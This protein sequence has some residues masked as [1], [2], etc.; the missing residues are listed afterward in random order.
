MFGDLDTLL[1]LAR[2][3]E[4]R[5]FFKDARVQALLA[6]PGFKKAVQEKNMFQLASHPKF[7]Q[8][9]QDPDFRSTLEGVIKKIP[10]NK[11]GSL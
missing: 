8:L 2:D 11:P 10:K 6:D 3:E 9:M 4:F 7:N 5:K 1:K